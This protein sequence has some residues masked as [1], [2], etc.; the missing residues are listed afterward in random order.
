MEALKKLLKAEDAPGV[1]FKAHAIKG[2]AANLSCGEIF[3]TALAMEMAAKA[4]DLEAVK[5]CL[6]DLERQFDRLKIVVKEAFP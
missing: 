1:Q 3:A 4:S 6:T 2:V 5:S